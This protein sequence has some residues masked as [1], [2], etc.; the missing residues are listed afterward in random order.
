MEL[1]SLYM[2]TITEDHTVKVENYIYCNIKSSGF[3]LLGA[4]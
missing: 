1:I 4:L 3:L 2:S